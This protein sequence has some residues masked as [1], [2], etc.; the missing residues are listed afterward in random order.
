M[1]LLLTSVLFAAGVM[2]N[3]DLL[4]FRPRAL[5]RGI[6]TDMARHRSRLNGMV[7]CRLAPAAVEGGRLFVAARA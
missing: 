3:I 4:R 1:R 2:L 6:L 5:M 7:G